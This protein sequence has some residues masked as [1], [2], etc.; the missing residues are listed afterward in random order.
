MFLQ[1]DIDTLN[2]LHKDIINRKE[3]SI[4][5]LIYL[6]EHLPKDI[7]HYYN[8]TSEGFNKETRTKILII[9][10]HWDITKDSTNDCLS[11]LSM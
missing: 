8:Q 10:K 1:S 4:Y 6:W 11:H 2:Q 9:L 7:W 3:N 5:D